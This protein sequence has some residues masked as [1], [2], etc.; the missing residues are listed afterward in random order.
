MS[1][2]LMFDP[3]SM[4]AVAAGVSR[5]RGVKVTCS[6]R[7]AYTTCSQRMA[8]NGRYVREL[9]INIPAEV[10]ETKADAAALLNWGFANFAAVT[11]G[12]DRPLLPLPVEM[13]R[14]DTVMPELGEGEVQVLPREGLNRL[15]KTL[16]LPESLQ[17]P[18]EK[19]QQI[20]Q[21]VVTLDGKSSN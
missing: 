13:G 16:E 15:E 20:G 9:A 1:S 14:Q 19:G 11:L 12:A 2:S 8:A 5:S 4:A 18:V 7:G 3:K 10:L 17:A 21:L 6:G